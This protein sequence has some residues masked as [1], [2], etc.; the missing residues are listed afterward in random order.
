[1]TLVGVSVNVSFAKNPTEEE[2]SPYEV[3]YIHVVPSVVQAGVLPVAD[4]S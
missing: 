1:M 4:L 2:L 3:A